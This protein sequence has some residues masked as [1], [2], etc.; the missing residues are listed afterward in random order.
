MKYL[1]KV[2]QLVG[3]GATA[4]IQ[5]VRFQ[6]FPDEESVMPLPHP[7]PTLGLKFQS[8]VWQWI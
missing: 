7:Q 4:G 1:V 6:T 5:V 8:W 2:A 3:N